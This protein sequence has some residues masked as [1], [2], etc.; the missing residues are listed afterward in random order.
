M[1][2]PQRGSGEGALNMIVNCEIIQI[3]AELTQKYNDGSI[4]RLQHVWIRPKDNRENTQWTS[5][6]E[7]RDEK[8]DEFA[9][10]GHQ[11][12]DIVPVRLKPDYYR[13]RRGG[14]ETE[15]CRSICYMDFWLGGQGN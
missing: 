12:N 8:I 13:V 6:L 11:V 2:L 5:L 14:E 1:V 15:E 7:L 10:S 3:D 4:H 9:A